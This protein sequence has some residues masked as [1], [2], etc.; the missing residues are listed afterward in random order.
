M[1]LIQSR[2]R[3]NMA[4]EEV[5]VA[6]SW[7]PA[8]PVTCTGIGWCLQV[9]WDGRDA[10]QCT[11]LASGEYECVVQA[12]RVPR[13]YCRFAAGGTD[14]NGSSTVKGIRP[15]VVFEGDGR[16]VKSVAVLAEGARYL[17]RHGFRAKGVRQLTR[18]QRQHAHA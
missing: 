12:S 11:G 5:K 9:A 18:R 16:M 2:F 15:F 6:L 14:D 10:Q 8:V 4:R 13:G 17:L 3:G 1:S 7:R